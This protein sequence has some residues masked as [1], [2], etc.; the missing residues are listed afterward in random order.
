VSILSR[1]PP[2]G[3][4]FLVLYSGTFIFRVA[5]GMSALLAIMVL[6]ALEFSMEALIFFAIAFSFVEGLI[7]GVTGY[8]TDILDARIVLLSATLVAALA[9]TIYILAYPFISIP[10]LFLIMLIIGHAVHGIA[11]SL[12]VTP[13]LAIITRFTTYEERARYMGIFDMTLMYG[14][15]VGI[16]LSGVVFSFFVALGGGRPENGLFG[17]TVLIILF[18]ATGLFFYFGLPHIPPERKGKVEH[19]WRR[20]FAHIGAGAK[21]MFSKIRRDIGITWFVFAALWG[22]A[23]NIGPYLLLRDFGIHQVETG[24]ITAIIVLLIGGTSPFWGYVA[25][26]IGRKKTA[27]IGVSGL[28]LI[29]FLGGLAVTYFKIPHT[30]VMFYILLAPGIFCLASIG[31]SFLGRLGD[32]AIMGERGVVASGFQFVTSMGEVFGT[33]VGGLGYIAGHMLLEGSSLKPFAG[34]IGIGIPAIIFFF[35]TIIFG[36]RI[37]HDE[38][39][40]REVRRLEEERLK[41]Q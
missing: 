5:F 36:L 24:F 18:I 28:L 12:K 16:A 4:V 9:M 3:K 29:A 10:L 23:Y 6:E 34:L 41:N 14:R 13:T 26:K 20:L 31:P 35:L 19:I 30:D 39:V 21:V 15:L 27:A 7:A 11:S 17:F 22:L 1:D 32:T 40:L 8:A 33:V 37:R 25:D 38:E 2:K